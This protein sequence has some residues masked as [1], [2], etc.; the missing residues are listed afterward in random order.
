[1]LVANGYISEKTSTSPCFVLVLS[2]ES[3][4]TNLTT[5][6]NAKQATLTSTTDVTLQD[7]TVKS[8]ETTTSQYA[9]TVE[10]KLI[11]KNDT[12]NLL[13]VQAKGTSHGEAN[14]VSIYNPSG[15]MD[16][17]M[18]THTDMQ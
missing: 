1:M 11:I 5:D 7:L 3:Q 14:K 8:V 18:N 17:G 6:L 16:I 10:T 9:N 2:P 15:E 12:N 4:I 13:E